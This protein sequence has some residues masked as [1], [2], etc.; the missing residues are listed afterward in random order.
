MRGFATIFGL[1]GVILG[2]GF[3]ISVATTHSI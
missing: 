2:T 1:I 3:W